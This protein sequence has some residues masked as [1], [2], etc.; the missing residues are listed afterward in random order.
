MTGGHGMCKKIVFCFLL[1]LGWNLW[2]QE[3]AVSPALTFKLTPCLEIPI[4]ASAE[5]HTLGGSGTFTTNFG[6]PI[7]FPLYISGDLGYGL[8]PF[9]LTST[10]RLNLLSVGS[11]AGIEAR[12]RGRLFGNAF[13]KGGYY[14]GITEDDLGDA[15]TG[16]NPYLWAGAELN[17]YLSQSFTLVIGG[18]YKNYLGNP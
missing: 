18:H 11:G 16:G 6:L 4:G 9:D 17:Y 12:I 13:L 5:R 15:V 7:K 14:Y 10:K 1:V 3:S 8:L 2:A